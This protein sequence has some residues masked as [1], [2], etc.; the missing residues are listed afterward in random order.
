M[1]NEIKPFTEE[2][3][4][5]PFIEESEFKILYPINREEYIKKIFDRL[6]KIVQERKLEVSIDY[7][8]KSI[9]IRT[10][11]DTRDPY[12]IIRGKDMIYFICR[13]VPIEGAADMLN[14]DVLYDIIYIDNIVKN[15]ET[16]IKRR[17]RIIGEKGVTQ[18]AIEL[19]TECKIW[20]YT[21]N[22]CAI[23]N[24][25]K[26]VKGL[27]QVRKIVLDCMNN[28]HPMY[29]IKRLMVAK[30]LET[31]ENLKNE[32]WERYLPSLKK[33]SKKEK[34]RKTKIKKKDSDSIFPKPPMPRKEDI[35]I[36]TGEYFINKK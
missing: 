2:D 11:K 21:K 24:S 9:F 4:P 25:K 17:D 22:V 1:K 8:K 14:D 12:I 35:M 33:S 31:D 10:T 30:E 6:I 26:G 13:G 7:S 20:V 29:Q 18:K 23:T 16:F 27:K 36:E 19:L 5:N 28:I 15:R 32:N 3:F 34:K